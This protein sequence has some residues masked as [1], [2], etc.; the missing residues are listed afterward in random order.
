MSPGFKNSGGLRC[1]P[2][3]LGVP[4]SITSPG[5]SVTQLKP[6]RQEI[7]YLG[8]KL[9]TH[10]RVK[11][12]VAAEIL[13]IHKFLWTRRKRATLL[14]FVFSLLRISQLKALKF[15]RKWL[16]TN[17]VSSPLSCQKC[18]NLVLKLISSYSPWNTTNNGVDFV[19]EFAGVAALLEDSV[20][21]CAD[22]EVVD[23]SD[24]IWRYDGGSQRAE[25]VHGFPEEELAAIPLLLP[26][27][28]RYVLRHRV[29][30]DMVHRAAGGDVVSSCPNYHRQLHLPVHLLHNLWVMFLSTH[31][32]TYTYCTWFFLVCADRGNKASPLI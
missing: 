13:F 30:E 3:P 10:L 17:R 9:N 25:R 12:L 19:N 21:F 15:N 32:T 18:W 11:T 26:V 22:S 8:R 29:A 14:P 27:A 7:P 6:R 16:M 4:V 2:T 28:C 24:G 5:S 31:D 20:D 1:M 23:I